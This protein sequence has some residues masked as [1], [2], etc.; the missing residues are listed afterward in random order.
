MISKTAPCT[1]KNLRGE[2]SILLYFVTPSLVP[3]F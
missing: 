3:Y 2:G 1:L